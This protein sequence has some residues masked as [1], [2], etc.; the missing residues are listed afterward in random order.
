MKFFSLV[1]GLVVLLFSSSMVNAIETLDYDDLQQCVADS[2]RLD[3]KKDQ[4]EKIDDELRE[5][6]SQADTLD[7]RLQGLDWD[8]DQADH[9]YEMCMIRNNRDSRYC[10]YEA[11]RLD[12]LADRYNNT[13]DQLR[14]LER[15]F[16]P[17]AE[18]ADRKEEELMRMF[19]A[20]NNS[21]FGVRY[22][23]SDIKEA[24]ENNQ[25]TYFCE[26]SP[27]GD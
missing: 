1:V 14:R 7:S 9:S 17:K 4:L 20:L 18:V 23:H 13:L 2:K 12:N 6:N 21:C 8:Y 11:Q 25:D 19:N 27:Q 3:N 16:N 5:I 15:E 22:K 10:P 24:C 26:K